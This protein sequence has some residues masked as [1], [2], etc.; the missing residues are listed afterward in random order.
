MRPVYAIGSTNAS[1]T[2]GAVRHGP[3]P[4]ARWHHRCDVRAPLREFLQAPAFESE[5]RLYGNEIR[6]PNVSSGSVSATGRFE[7]KRRK[8]SSGWCR[9]P[10]PCNAD[11]LRAI[12]LAGEPSRRSSVSWGSGRA[13][14]TSESAREPPSECDDGGWLAFV[15][16]GRGRQPV[17]RHRR[18]A[19]WME[20]SQQRAKLARRG[21][22][23]N[24][25]LNY[26]VRTKQ[27]RLP[28]RDAERLGGSARGL[29]VARKWLDEH[30]CGSADDQGASIDH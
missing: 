16:S 28:D 18:M 15:D 17:N 6:I 29:R 20:H 30:A 12:S 10:T 24:G 19:V 7:P 27:Q 8:P 21:A 25:S 13:G 22:T 26:L 14:Q 9:S 1:R 23:P 11:P 4:P 3:S 2:G 5:R